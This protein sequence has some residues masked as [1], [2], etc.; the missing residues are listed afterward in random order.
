MLVGSPTQ[1]G[2]GACSLVALRSLHDDFRAALRSLYDDFLAA[3][4]SPSW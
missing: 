2:V 4:C 1:L 3:L